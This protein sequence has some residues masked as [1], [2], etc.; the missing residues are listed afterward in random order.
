MA[1]IAKETA[2]F[3]ADDDTWTAQWIVLDAGA[4][5]ARLRREASAQTDA[6]CAAAERKAEKIRRQASMQAAAI[7]D[8]AEREAAQLRVMAATLSAGSGGSAPADAANANG[9]GVAAKVAAP[10]LRPVAK[11]AAGGKANARGRQARVMRK[12]VA[13]YAVLSLIGGTTAA[14]EIRLHGLSF[15]L[16]RNAGTGA[17]NPGDLDEDQG[18]GQP[19][20]P[21]PHHPVATVGTQGK[22]SPRGSDGH[23]Q[24]G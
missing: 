12:V 4:Q 7:R 23:G 6:I 14:V 3:L 15:F 11:P 22:P 2:E 1:V 20:A 24:Q 9:G 5:A 19:D 16:F 13:A 8:A 17:G 21:R 10:P 18:P